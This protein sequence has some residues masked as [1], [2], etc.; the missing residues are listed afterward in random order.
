ML[1]SLIAEAKRHADNMDRGSE[2]RCL[3]EAS[4]YLRDEIEGKRRLLVKGA[5]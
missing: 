4:E 5:L 1:E 3:E 2:L